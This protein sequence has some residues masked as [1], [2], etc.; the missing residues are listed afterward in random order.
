MPKMVIEV[1]EEFA[2][3]GKAMAAYLAQTLW[4]GQLQQQG[5]R[6]DVTEV[7]AG[8]GWLWFGVERSRPAVAASLTL[9]QMGLTL[10]AMNLWDVALGDVALMG[11]GPL[12]PGSTLTLYWWDQASGAHHV[13]QLSQTGENQFSIVGQCIAG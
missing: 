2:E 1:P 5:Y 6:L 7:S 10:D 9:V 13:A 12:A 8:S 11:A 3:V 4:S